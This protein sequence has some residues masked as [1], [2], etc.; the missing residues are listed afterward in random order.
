MPT[1]SVSK[2]RQPVNIAVDAGLLKA[3]QALGV[4]IA[5]AAEVGIGEAVAEERAHLW[6][7][8]NRAALE[9]W[10]G[11]VE[12]EGLPLSTHRDTLWRGTTSS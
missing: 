5:R 4:D 8:E 1:K 10:N 7:R 9:A 11:Y 12:R 3:A 2:R 6:K